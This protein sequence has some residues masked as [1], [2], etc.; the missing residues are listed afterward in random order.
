M[1]SS[2]CLAQCSICVAVWPTSATS[3]PAI[4]RVSSRP[5]MAPMVGVEELRRQYLTSQLSACESYRE[6]Q[7]SAT[8]AQDD[9]R[10]RGAITMPSEQMQTL[11]EALR[12]RVPPHG[13]F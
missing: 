1:D 2:H 12:Q 13:T 7:A 11:L 6:P 5:G 3:S 10:A 9:R 4:S 8:G